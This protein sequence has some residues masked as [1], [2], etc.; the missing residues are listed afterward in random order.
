MNS[1]SAILVC[2]RDQLFRETLKNF[3]LAAGYAEVEI[4]TTARSALAMLRRERFA[5][6]LI[7]MSRPFSCRRRLAAIAQQRQPQAKV[8]MLVAAED[9]PLIHDV[10]FEYIIKEHVFSSIMEL[11]EEPASAKQ[12]AKIEK[13]RGKRFS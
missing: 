10:S 8:F 3:L 12:V 13:P 5:C 11:L 7:G 4:V 6:V 1:C 9:H 2:D